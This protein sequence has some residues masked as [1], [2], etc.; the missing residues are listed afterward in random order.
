MILIL[1]V[2]NSMISPSWGDWF[3]CC[4]RAS[5]VARAKF[6]QEQARLAAEMG[7]PKWG[8]NPACPLRP[9]APVV[10]AKNV[11]FS[12]PLVAAPV[13]PAAASEVKS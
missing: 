12:E 7:A 6:L 8:Q 11:R 5:L 2:N 1:L 9:V 13:I 10:I 3:G 4:S